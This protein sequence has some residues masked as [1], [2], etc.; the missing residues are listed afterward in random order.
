MDVKKA[1]AWIN[2]QFRN[3]SP[4]VKKVSLLFHGGGEPTN[5]PGLLKGLTEL[6][7]EKM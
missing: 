5:N 7:R 4:R 1:E 6:V 3:I 2:Y